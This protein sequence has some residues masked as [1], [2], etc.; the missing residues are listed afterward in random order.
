VRTAYHRDVLELL[1]LLAAIGGGIVASV[2]GFGIG[3]LVTPVL[4]WHVDA[5]LAVAV[6]SIPHFIGTAFRFWRLGGRIDRRVLGSFGVMSAAGGL[7][8]A[9]LQ[10]RATTPALLLLFG[11]LLLFSSAAELT[12]FG[13]RM[14]FHGVIAWI[15]GALS[16]LLG[17]LVGNQGGIRSAALLGVDLPKQTFV[18]TATAVAL[19]V[20]A[21]RV[22]VYLWYMGGAM[23]QRMSWMIVATL[24]VVAGTAAGLSLLA[25][26]PERSFRRVVAILLAVLGGAMLVRGISQ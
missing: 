26:I 18:A 24:G 2:A 13:R 16:G 14:Q 6:V 7:A 12:G 25:R 11:G 22:P 4:A 3:S 5:K 10:E 17:G 21:A 1:I 8:G 19:L 23:G 15:A 20:D 9:L